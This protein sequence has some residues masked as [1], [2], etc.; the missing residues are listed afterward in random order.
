MNE[1]TKGYTVHT[2]KKKYTRITSEAHTMHV[3]LLC[4]PYVTRGLELGSAQWEVSCSY[5]LHDSDS[6][7][8]VL[9]LTVVV[10]CSDFLSLTVLPTQT[11]VSLPFEQFPSQTCPSSATRTLSPTT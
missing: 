11:E 9:S 3:S 1:S 4:V 7:E 8:L 6:Q 5:L 2:V 10:L